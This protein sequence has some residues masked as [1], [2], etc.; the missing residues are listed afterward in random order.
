MIP[1]EMSG[2]TGLSSQCMREVLWKENYERA[3]CIKEMEADCELLPWLAINC[4]KTTIF[5]YKCK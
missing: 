4:R 3:T 2:I 1:H 5:E